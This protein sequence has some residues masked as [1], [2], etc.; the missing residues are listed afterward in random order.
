MKI[1]D[2]IYIN[3]KLFAM[4]YKYMDQWFHIHILCMFTPSFWKYQEHLSR[5]VLGQRQQFSWLTVEFSW[6]TVEFKTKRNN[7]D[8]VLTIKCRIKTCWRCAMFCRSLFVL[9]SFFFWP[10]CCLS[11]FDLRILT[12]TSAEFYS[13][14]AELL[15][16]TFVR[17]SATIVWLFFQF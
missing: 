12:T 5:E 9:L 17:L 13:E 2:I 14:S 10:L 4:T 8:R 6:L 16:L 11:F 3:R 15:S 1:Y 7:V